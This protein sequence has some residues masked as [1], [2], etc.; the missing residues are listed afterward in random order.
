MLSLK[1]I[2]FQPNI[3]KT[4]DEVRISAPFINFLNYIKQELSKNTSNAIK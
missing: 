2:K 3:N 4:T 1:T